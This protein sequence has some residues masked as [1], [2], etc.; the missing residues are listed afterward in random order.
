ML[1]LESTI[2]DAA[3]ATENWA[4]EANGGQVRTRGV[5]T[6]AGGTLVTEGGSITPY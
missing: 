5:V 4:V 2:A 6:V 1:W 3:G